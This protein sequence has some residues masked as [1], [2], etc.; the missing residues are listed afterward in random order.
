MAA[1]PNDLTRQQLDD[2]DALLQRM[3]ALP[4]NQDE[5][6]ATTT[7]LPDPP[8]G[9]RTDPPAPPATS[10]LG[11]TPAPALAL[12]EPKT[13]VR[14]LSPMELPDP[15]PAPMAFAPSPL[16]PV[17]RARFAPPLEVPIEMRTASPAPMPFDHFK[18]AEL[19]ARPDE[20]PTSPSLS[21]LFWPL[22]AVNWLLENAL[23][24]FGPPGEMLTRPAM[25]NC[26]GAVGM[27]LLIAA[28]L[29]AAQG[30]GW[31]ALPLDQL[32]H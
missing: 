1:T 23:K 31:I 28:G 25:K 22:F 16:L 15:G 12:A 30:Q 17:E 5:P 29:W 8:N 11:R 27:L 13:L 9:W 7:A 32:P 4:L 2:L 20:T 26:L 18:L 10:H 24:L 21:P 14:P 19:T 6:A 3:L